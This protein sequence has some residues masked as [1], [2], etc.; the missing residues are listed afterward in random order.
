MFTNYDLKLL[1]SIYP[2]NIARKHF[3]IDAVKNT[4]RKSTLF[5]K[6]LLVKKGHEGSLK[7]LCENF[8]KYVK[9]QMEDK[10]T[11]IL[12]HEIFVD[13]FDDS[14]IHFLEKYENNIL[15]G[16][17]NTSKEVVKFMESVQEFIEEPVG[18]S[19]YDIIDGEIGVAAVQ[20]GPKGEGG[21]DDATGAGGR[22]G[23]STQQ[24]SAVV[25]LGDKKRGEDGDSWGVGFKFP[26][27]K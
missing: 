3:S 9:M 24:T 6:T 21:L 13:P 20:G 19:L 27:Q 18:M 17:F 14:K 26:W 11:G 16:R 15:L 10:N 12:S 8:Q 2:C 5:S 25:N 4:K 7:I 1:H 22:G 23:A